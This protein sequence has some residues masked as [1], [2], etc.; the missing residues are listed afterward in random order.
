MATSNI[1]IT[2]G[3]GQNVATYNFTEDAITKD[4]G[5]TVI[6][7][8]SGT[9]VGTSANPTQVSLANTGANSNKLLVTPDSVALPSN[10]SVNE[11][12]INGVAPLM[13]NGVTGTGSQRVTI[14]SDNT[15]FAVNSTLSAET[16]KV[17]GTVNQGTSPWVVSGTVTANAGTNLNTSLLAVE[18]GGNLAAIKTDVDKIPSQ[19]QALA[20]ASMPVVL[21]SAQITT[22]TPPSNTGYALDAS[23]TTLDTDVKSNITLHAGTNLIGKVGIDQT[24]PG[25]TNKVSIGTDGVVSTTTTDTAPVTQNVTVIDSA[26][27]STISSNQQIL[28][29]G[30]PTVGSVA[31]FSLSSQESVRVEVTGTWTG[32]LTSEI[33]IDNGTTWF[34][35]GL[36]QGAYTISTFQGNFVGGGSVTGATNYRLR[37][38][39]TMTGTAVVKIISSTNTNSVYIAN[40]APSGNIVSTVNSSVATLTSGSVFTGAGE[41]ASNFSEVR[42]SVF[43]S[44]ASAT[45][46]LSMQQ[47]P[48]NSN[49]D[50]IDT[51]T[52]PATTGKTFVVP[53]QAR[54]FRVVYT[55]GGT[56]Q[57]SFRLQTILNRVGSA[58]SSQRT[59][60]GYSNENDFEQNWVFPSMYNGATWDR[61]RGNTTN[62]MQIYSGTG[63]LDI[64]KAED[65]GHT[66]G[67]TGVMALGVRN[68]T[69]ADRTST[70]ADYS[71]PSTDVKGRLITT[72]APRALKVQQQT[73]LTASTAETTILTAVASTFLDLYGL[74]I[75]NSSGTGANI[76]IKDATAGT[77]RMN[78]WVPA[79]DTRGFMLSMDAAHNQAALNNNWTATSSASVTSILITALA[80]KSI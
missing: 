72:G 76:T 79:N 17:I 32:T 15:A 78:F 9:E 70:D 22:L 26:S 49:W 21:P 1:P 71:A 8:S 20:A 27:T 16:T 34:A 55:N 40:A 7:N 4:V 57:T 59:Q 31:S 51:Y 75:T 3:T 30:T 47:S 19:G 50:V 43:A 41:D 62:G 13:G 46:G 63:T 36:H 10:Q 61:V 29:T 68:D 66:S 35:Q 60:D 25:T 5:R 24:T 65:A 45:D 56:N 44:H 18:S 11:S 14:A 48:D 73:A 58:S 28:V 52:I 2:P 74:I 54:Y 38:T 67:D 12:Q 6:N 77:T 42:V 39:A 69:L 80:V 33:S 64:G 53:R 23:L 37:A